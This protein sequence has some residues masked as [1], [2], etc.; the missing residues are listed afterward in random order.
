[1]LRAVLALLLLRGTA[2]FD[3]SMLLV[4]LS[5]YAMRVCIF[6]FKIIIIYIYIYIYIYMHMHMH[7]IL[8]DTNGYYKFI[9]ITDY[10]LY[11]FILGLMLYILV[12]YVFCTWR[13]PFPQAWEQKAVSSRTHFWLG[14]LVRNFSAPETMDLSM[15]YMSG[16]WFGNLIMVIVHGQL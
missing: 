12:G 8:S 16:W 11:F 13:L 4:L 7:I 2:W 15:K 5:L 1:M 9:G 14:G 3:Q 6:L 10:G